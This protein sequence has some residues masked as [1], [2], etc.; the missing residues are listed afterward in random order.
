MRFA[1]IAVLASALVPGAFAQHAGGAGGGAHS[2]GAGARVGYRGVRPPPSTGGR[3]ILPYPG[4][5]LYPGYV[6]PFYA[7]DTDP[8]DYQAQ[9]PS[10]LVIVNPYF[11][12]EIVRP[13]IKDYSN[14]SLP[15]PGVTI[16]APGTAPAPPAAAQT[17]PANDDQPNMFLIALKD[18]SVLA[19]VAYWVQDD[20]LNYITM[21]GAH[22]HVSVSAVDRDLSIRL[23]AER[24]VQFRLAIP[25]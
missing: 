23:N 11:Q 19:S 24:Q 8:G 10:P 2:G 18:G 20:T 14:V 9:P 6:D 7:G 17:R 12:P 1:V 5:G 16:V 3:A 4:Y 21:A 22:N 15:E 25:H 13:Q